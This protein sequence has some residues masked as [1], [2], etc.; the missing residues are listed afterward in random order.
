MSRPH[1]SQFLVVGWICSLA[2]LLSA[3]AITTQAD[4]ETDKSTPAARKISYDKD[5]RP[6][7]QTHCQGCHQP[8][9]K[10]GDY[11]M[12]DFSLLLKGGESEET[13]IVAN[14]PDESHLISLISK[15]DG[16]AEMPQ[17]KKPLADSE[18]DLIR[19]WI[20][21]GAGNDSP[22]STRLRYSPENP[23]VYVAA[24]II[25]SVDFSSDGKYLAISG[26]HEVLL[27]RA[28]GSEL[29]A[30]LIGLSERI[31]SARFSPDGS[32]LAVAGGSPGRMGELQ[33]WKIEGAE[34]LLALTAGY[35]TIYGAN[36]SPDS[37]LV[38]YGCPDATIH[39][40]NIDDGTEVL[41][42]GAHSDWVLDTVF[43]KEGDHLVTVSRDR[44][45]KLINVK[46]SQFIDN[47]TSITP[48]AL[49]GG[50]HA[51]DRH[52]DKDELLAGGV[53]GVP[54][55]YK[56]VRDK[57][58]KIGDDYNLIRAFPKLKGRIFSTRFS[59]DGS[60]IVAGSSFNGSGQIKIANYAD[61]KEI[62]SVDIASGIFTVAFHPDGKT[63]A[64]GGFD[65][66]IY[67]IDAATGTIAKQFVPVEIQVEVAKTK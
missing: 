19:Q 54:K 43:S 1:T 51:V 35:D 18:I 16:A 63:I 36:W 48:G 45:M 34:L 38:S 65:G 57:A 33:V 28:D 13:A 4:D 15:T 50:L 5:I 22:A 49:K 30:R 6:I 61:G 7:F 12:T 44:S 66:Y 58:R 21:Q 11:V 32:M 10:G 62:A 40:V 47:I 24:P 8:S 59:H 29:I 56:M 17:G 39:A 26:F 55:V 25:T 14:K 2:L 31:E 52:P 67:L 60:R 20:T 3:M 64:A 27:Y 42:N 23:P 9:K 41:F 46:T 37:N 53:D